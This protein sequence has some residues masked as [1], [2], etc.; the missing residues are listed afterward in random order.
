VYCAGSHYSPPTKRKG[1]CWM[2]RPPSS[3]LCDGG[4]TAADRVRPGGHP[5]PTPDGW[6]VPAFSSVAQTARP[7]TRSGCPTR[8]ADRARR[9]YVRIIRRGTDSR[10]RH[11]PKVP[12]KTAARTRH[13]SALHPTPDPVWG[14]VLRDTARPRRAQELDPGEQ[15]SSSHRPDQPKR[16]IL[17]GS[18]EPPEAW[19]DKAG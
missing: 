9:A 2:G 19:I 10:T 11:T 8:G 17:R 4:M 12:N 5:S 16:G 6:S 15:H 7:G 13:R 1:Y 3:P 14:F 18:K